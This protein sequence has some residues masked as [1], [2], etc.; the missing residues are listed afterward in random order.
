MMDFRLS[1]SVL[2]A[3]GIPE[4]G[5]V[6]GNNFW[7]GSS[8]G[9]DSARKPHAL[10][11]SKRFNRHMHEHLMTSIAPFDIDYRVIYASHSSPW[12]VQVEFYLDRAVNLM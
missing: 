9:C 3:S 4:S 12:Q 8:K 1:I 10:V 2:D 5:F 7:L 11:I 6:L